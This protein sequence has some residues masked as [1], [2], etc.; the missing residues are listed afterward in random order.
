M[1]I[2]FIRAFSLIFIAEL[3]D[4]SQ[5]IAMTLSTKYKIKKVIIGLSI[6]IFVN[7]TLAVL[8][9][10][11]LNRLIDFSLIS[12]V[13]GI[14]FIIFGLWSLNIELD[15]ESTKP[16]KLNPIISIAIIFFVSE[17][18]DK[19]QLTA[20]TLASEATYPLIVL[21][22]TVMGMIFT[23]LMGIYLGIKMGKKIPITWI[24][25]ISSTVFIIIG[26]IKLFENTSIDHLYLYTSFAVVLSIYTL[27]LRRLL[28]ILRTNDSSFERSAEELK[29]YFTVIKSKLDNICLG[30]T[31]CGSCDGE[32]CLIGYT[33]RLIVDALLGKEVDLNY[34]TQKRYKDFDQ[35]KVYQALEL[36]LKEL[37]KDWTNSQNVILHQVREN[38]ERI[39]FSDSISA[40]S[41]G[42]YQKQLKKKSKELGLQNI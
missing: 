42:I 21:F 31:H 11:S 27:L 5:I 6:G 19:T 15:D 13:A 29:Y 34:I 35:S 32:Q 28:F 36:T 33:K 9:G 22:G 18:G 40:E 8:I 37:K 38:L 23:G 12:L 1:I 24:K 30:E 25:L 41:Y 39:L 20:I 2:E 17:L 10:A 26:Y 4:K 3:G 14:L 16:F 7:H